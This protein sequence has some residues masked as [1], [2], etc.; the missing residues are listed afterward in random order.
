MSGVTAVTWTVNPAVL[1]IV[2]DDLSAGL[3][4]DA[5]GAIEGNQTSVGEAGGTVEVTAALSLLGGAA[6]P[7]GIS[8]TLSL[9]ETTDDDKADMGTGPGDDFVLVDAA[10]AELSSV[11]LTIPS[12]QSTASAILRLK[13]TDDRTVE[14]DETL[15]VSVSSAQFII[16]SATLT[17]LDDDVDLTVDDSSV[18]EGETD[19]ITV[20]ATVGKAAPA[21]GHTVAVS[22]ADSADSSAYTAAAAD[23]TASPAAFDVNITAGQKSGTASFDLQGADDTATEDTETVGATGALSGFQVDPAVVSI[24]DQDA[25]IEVSVSPAKVVEQTGAPQTITVTA[26]F[27]GADASTRS[28]ATSVTITISGGTATIGSGNDFVT[29]KTGNSFTISIPAGSARRTG[30]F[31]LTARADGEDEGADGETVTVSASATVDGSA[32][33]ASTTLSILDAG[34]ELSFEDSEGAALTGLAEEG[35]SEQ[36][37]VK[38]SLLT[39]ITAPA[40]GAVV[41]VNVIGG[42]AT[43][44]GNSDWAAGEDFRVTYPVRPSGTLTGYSLGIPISA[45]QSS[46]TAVITVAL[47]NDDVAEGAETILAQGAEVALGSGVTLP[48]ADSSLNIV[49]DDS[50]ISLGFGSTAADEDDGNAGDA[51][52]TASFA[53]TSSVISNAVEVTLSFSDGTA[54]AAGNID[55]TAPTS[56]NEITVTIPALSTASS[57]VALTNLTIADDDRAEG[58]ETI[59]VG[60]AAAGFTV[61]NASLS[62]EDNDLGVTLIVDTDSVIG[63]AQTAL[64]EDETPAVQGLRPVHHGHR[65]GTR[66]AHDGLGK[67]SGSLDRFGPGRRGRFPGGGGGRGDHHPG[68]LAFRLSGRPDRAGTHR[69]RHRRGRRN[70]RGQRNPVRRRGGRGGCPRRAENRRRRRG[71]HLERGRNRRGGGRQRRGRNGNRLLRRVELGVDFGYRGDAVVCGGHGGGRGDRFHGA[72]FGQRDHGE[73]PGGVDQQSGGGVDGFD[74]CRR[75][76]GGAVGDG[77]GGRVGAGGARSCR[78]G[79]A[80]DCRRRFEGGVVRRVVDGGRGRRGRFGR[81]G[82]GGLPVDYH[83]LGYLLRHGGYLVGGGRGRRRALIIPTR[84]GRRT[85]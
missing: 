32:R 3:T 2:D 21:G 64:A 34:V 54:T 72:G 85:R 79:G 10:G 73:H 45:G 22:I 28:S 52:V 27:A 48:A 43:I 50:V 65:L 26:G 70:L 66:F 14:P 9:T 58:T 47:N 24:V 59:T 81:V 39:G 40:G 41:S 16:G 33:T 36:V 38:A 82:V 29:D 20:T 42:T 75:H 56:G 5:D 77:N 8:A 30:T 25:G 4:V 17:I 68:S 7:G 35:G 53:A 57:A 55:Y 51:M 6:P 71:N 63:G 31:A 69:R 84:R 18:N 80:V 60:G 46:G 44:D 15:A 61:G 78:L 12:G 67:R 76:E 11:D 23:Y 49:D 83:R 37:T 74:G 1:T 13:L 19:S 62:V